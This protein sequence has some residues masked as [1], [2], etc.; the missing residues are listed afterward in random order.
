MIRDKALG[1]F[2]CLGILVVLT[3][4]PDPDVEF[5]DYTDRYKDVNGDGTGG[6]LNVG[7]GCTIAAG[8]RDGDYFFSLV[9]KQS[10]VKPVTF[11]MTLTTTDGANGVEYSLSLQPLSAVDHVTPSGPVLSVGPFPV[12]P[13]GSFDSQWPEL[14]V[15]GD[16]N[17]INDN[18]LIASVNVVGSLCPAIPCGIVNGIVASG[19]VM[20][21]LDGGS[22]FTWESKDTFTEP[23]K[24][25]C[26]G[27]LAMP[28]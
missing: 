1:S 12:E 8:E 19:P 25:N 16:S 28:L 27:E 5:A 18:D 23:P 22:T 4:C 11:D 7:G 24:L 6:M 9:A 21:P 14:T 26:S 13:D 3:G 10:P 17:P 15:L 2:I 20:L